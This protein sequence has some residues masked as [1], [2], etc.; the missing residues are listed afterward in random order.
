MAWSVSATGKS[1]SASRL[2]CLGY[3]EAELKM[4]QPGE[5]CQDSHGG[6]VQETHE[7]PDLGAEG[8]LF[9]AS[10]PRKVFGGDMLH[11]VNIALCGSDTVHEHVCNSHEATPESRRRLSTLHS[12]HSPSRYHCHCH[13]Q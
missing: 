4:H 11:Y 3:F 5:G 8:S 7:T 2:R 6:I 1:K 10:K 13:H 12:P 9:L